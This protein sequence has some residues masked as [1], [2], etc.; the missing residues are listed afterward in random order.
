MTYSKKSLLLNFIRTNRGVTVASSAFGFL[1]IFCAL[2]I[3]VFLGKFYQLALR[4]HSTRAT[5]FDR[6]FE[7]MSDIKLYFIL[8]G[9]LILLKF[10][11]DYCERYFSGIGSERF[12]RD[13]REL[14]FSKQLYT[15]LAVFESKETGRYLLRYSGD[16]T[17][18]QQYLT[19]G[20]FSFIKDSFFILGGIALLLSIN[21]KLSLLVILLFPLQF[22]VVLLINRKLKSLTRSRRNTRSGNLS[23]V[24]SRL[25]GILTL[26]VFNREKVEEAKFSKRSKKLYD[27]GREYHA[28]Y[29]FLKALLPFM[30][31]MMLGAVLLYAYYINHIGEKGI[32]GSVI[33]V[34]ILQVVNFIPAMKRILSVNIVWQ[35]GDVSFQN[36]LTLL[37]AEEE[38]GDLHTEELRV[39]GSI[40]FRSLG[41]RYESGVKVYENLLSF[42]I[43]GPGITR[44]EGP[45]GSGKT[46]L[47]K[48]ILGL[49][50]PAQGEILID[51]QDISKRSTHSLR[52]QITMVSDELPLIGNTVFEAISYSRKAGKRA[53]ALDMLR[54]LQFRDNPEEATLDMHLTERARNLPASERKLLLIARALLTRKQIL[55][56]DEPFADLDAKHREIVIALLNELKQEH[57]ILLIDKNADRSVNTD[58]VI[59]LR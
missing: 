58:Q 18:L 42:Q 20:V 19:L 10:I 52:K 13:V 26:K 7:K 29:A 33:L 4:T 24:S 37:N 44:I 59:L 48:L 31:Y 9:I 34:F 47:F 50:N 23:F 49:Y 43:P 16:L 32:R 28:W 41:F 21:F 11:F 36:I 6:M 56:L 39:K 55:L 5:V 46:T 8:F 25:H 51:D 27:L 35:A 57:T 40:E 45:A 30:L 53:P 1:S 14:L 17:A 22:L 2:L 12:S 15:R 3:P 38:P 54:T